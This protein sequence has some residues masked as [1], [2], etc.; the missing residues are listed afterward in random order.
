NVEKISE[1]Q[2]SEFVEGQARIARCG[3]QVI[4]VSDDSRGPGGAAVEAH[5]RKHARCQDSSLR[6]CWS[7]LTRSNCSNGSANCGSLL[8]VLLLS[9]GWQVR[10]VIFMINT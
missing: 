7:S 6:S 4:V 10:V 9:P 5:G 8:K 1:E 3:S 2:V